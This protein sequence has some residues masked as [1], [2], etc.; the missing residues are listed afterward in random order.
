MRSRGSELGVVVVGGGVI[1][2]LEEMGW[3]RQLGRTVE[4]FRSPPSHALRTTT[5]E[6]S[7]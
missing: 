1:H 2:F 6:K 5:F 4:G 3:K 7:R